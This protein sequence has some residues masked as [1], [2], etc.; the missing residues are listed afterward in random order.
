MKKGVLQVVQYLNTLVG[1]LLYKPIINL[2]YFNYNH[3]TVISKTKQ[4]DI[5]RNNIKVQS[6]LLWLL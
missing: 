2:I 4:K 1:K 6:S 3:Q 5:I